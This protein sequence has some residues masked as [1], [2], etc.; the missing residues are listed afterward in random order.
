MKLQAELELWAKVG[1]QVVVAVH[2]VVVAGV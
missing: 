2:V 1:Q